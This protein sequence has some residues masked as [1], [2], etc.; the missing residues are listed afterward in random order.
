MSV[1]F[2]R[3]AA[4]GRIDYDGVEACAVRFGDPGADI[5]LGRLVAF[6]GLAHVMGESAAA[7]RSLSHDNLTAVAREKPDRRVVD[8]RVED[9]LRATCH[10]RYAFT[11]NA[12]GRENLRSVVA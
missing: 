8:V 12:L 2:D 11:P 10:Q 5:S 3:G 1:V 6:G 7:T 4:A 9:A